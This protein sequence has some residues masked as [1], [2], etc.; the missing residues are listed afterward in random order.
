MEAIP[1][2]LPQSA[3]RVLIVEDSAL[4]QKLLAKTLEENSNISVVGTAFNGKEAL[5]FLSDHTVDII[6]LD[7]EMPIM[8]GL[9]VLPEIVKNHPSPHIIMCSTLTKKN[10]EISLKALELGATDF[11]TKPATSSVENIFSQEL[12]QKVLLL[13]QTNKSQPFIADPVHRT[14]PVCIEDPVHIANDIGITK[15]IATPTNLSETTTS[16]KRIK[17]FAIGCSTGGPNA[18]KVFFSQLGDKLLHVPIFITQHMPPTFT[19]ILAENIAAISNRPCLE[20]ADGNKVTPGTIY[21]APGSYHMKCIK[22]GAEVYIHLTEEAPENFCRPAVDPML[23]SLASIYR[24]DLLTLILTGMGQDGLE[25]CKAVH[26]AGGTIILQDE[27][28]SV[29][30]GMPG[31]VAKHNLSSSILPLDKIA[32]YISTLCGVQS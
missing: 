10:A 29:V 25:G 19:P 21:L 30:W 7:I 13:G 8:D 15:T 28:S 17:A 27:V 23:R 20:A 3:I 16:P 14:N 24:T 5:S 32:S 18:L 12:V 11:I 1:T 6:L 4:V 31:T 9:T 26:K 22:K 2:S